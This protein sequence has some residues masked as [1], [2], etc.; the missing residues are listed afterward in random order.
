MESLRI[1]ISPA[2]SITNCGGCV[3][4]VR[5]ATSINRSV[6][7]DETH[8]AH[9]KTQTIRIVWQH[10][11]LAARAMEPRRFHRT[12]FPGCPAAVRFSVLPDSY[13][14]FTPPH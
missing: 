13:T 4:E 9:R 14:I 3:D 1:P 12:I 11:T 8:R 10:G 7:P 5:I 6:V 2:Q